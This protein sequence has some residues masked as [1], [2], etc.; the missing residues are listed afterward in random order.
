[1]VQQFVYVDD[2]QVSTRMAR[3]HFHHLMLLYLQCLDPTAILGC[4][5]RLPRVV[6]FISDAKLPRLGPV[7]M[8]IGG[9]PCQGHSCVGTGRRLEDPMFSFFWDLI[10]LMQ[11]WFVHQP[12]PPRYI[13]TVVAMLGDSRDKMLEGMLMFINTLVKGHN[14]L[15]PFKK[16]LKPWLQKPNESL[17]SRNR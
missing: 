10:P 15:H 6:A 17:N 2:N 11:C 3:H 5:V 16:E 8:M 4:F 1:M 12:S 9:W 14:G 13:F 7:D